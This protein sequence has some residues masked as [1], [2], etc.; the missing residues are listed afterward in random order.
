MF[1]SATLQ[2]TGWYL[3]VLMAISLLFS[4]IL[5]Q[6]ADNEINTRLEN[7][8]ISLQ[9]NPSFVMPQGITYRDLR[10]AQAREAET[11]I[12]VN[13][14]YINILVLSAG[15]VISYLLAR[16]T[17]RPIEKNHELQSRFASN[18]SHELRTPLAVMK[19]ELEVALRDKNINL[20]EMRE[21]LESNLE[22]V[23]K[24]SKLSHMLLQL[25]RSDHASLTMENVNLSN[26][27]N[28][29]THRFDKTSQRI[30]YTKTKK[31][32][33]V[34]GNTISIE[35]LVTIV[36]DNALKYSPPSSQVDVSLVSKGK[37]ASISIKNSGEG[38]AEADLPYIFDRFYRADNSRTGGETS[39]FGLG[40]SLAKQIVQLH[41][42]ELSVASAKGEMTTFTIN[43]PLKSKTQ[44]LPSK[45]K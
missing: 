23:D 31:Q 19:T 16:R 7:I 42:G 22:E 38:I 27:I 5:Y 25:S 17:L 30:H 40:L 20:A 33:L 14:A 21:I 29:V 35:E 2:L 39:G 28:S 36:L 26:L 34:A 15:G 41:G 4:I 32:I 13:I 44:Q 37:N 11:N 24:L 45:H 6:V 8:R 10:L 3:L 1:R 43:L 9:Q 12:L 18:A